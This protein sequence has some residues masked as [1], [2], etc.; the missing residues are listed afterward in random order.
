M[1]ATRVIVLILLVAL[2]VY[3][4]YHAREG[5]LVPLA[6]LITLGLGAAAVV[7]SAR[8]GGNDGP[9]PTPPGSEQARISFRRVLR[10]YFRSE[11]WLVLLCLA[12]Y[13]SF[14]SR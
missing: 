11:G 8:A 13:L 4:A 12:V 14:A 5:H 3:L 2:A 6:H 9:K 7:L 1:H 10:D